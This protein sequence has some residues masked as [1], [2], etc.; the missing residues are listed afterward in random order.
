MTAQEYI[1]SLPKFQWLSL[2]Q[3][4]KELFDEV[5]VLLETN[6]FEKYRIGWNETQSNL[7]MKTKRSEK[8][9]LLSSLAELERGIGA[10]DWIYIGLRDGSQY[11][12]SIWMNGNVREADNTRTNEIFTPGKPIQEYFEWIYKHARNIKIRYLDESKYT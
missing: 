11:I 2:A 9:Q 6:Q 4:P 1:D 8:E 5:W 12:V 3:V 10:I 7:F